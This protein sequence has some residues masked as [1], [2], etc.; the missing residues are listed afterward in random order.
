MMHLGIINRIFYTRRILVRCNAL[1]HFHHRRAHAMLDRRNKYFSWGIVLLSS[2]F[3][4]SAGCDSGGE[5]QPQPGSDSEQVRPVVIALNYPLANVAFQLAGEWIDV[6]CPV[7][8]NEDPAFWSPDDAQIA[9]LQ[10]A[11]LV[12]LNGAGHETWRDRVMLS[13]LNLTFTSRGFHDQWI[14]L[15]KAVTHQHGPEGEHSHSDFATTT[16]LDPVLFREQVY[17]VGQTLSKLLPDNRAEILG[18]V[19]KMQAE[20]EILDQKWKSLTEKLEART[21]IA[22]HPVYQYLTKRYGW[23]LQSLHWEPN[24]SLS[25]K[26]WKQFDQLQGKN[27]AT[28]MLWEAEPTAKTKEE[29]KKRG[30]NII[31]VKPL[32]NGPLKENVIKQMEANAERFTAELSKS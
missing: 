26:D 18:R 5:E 20:L 21:L 17:V 2:L 3:L 10:Q 24:Q 13:P 30:V 8:E 9:A 16:W 27:K 28:L 25:E 12:L 11:N 32:G 23:K 29:L 4:V 1:R 6:Q 19:E 31:I 22:S 7:P 15:D 14:K